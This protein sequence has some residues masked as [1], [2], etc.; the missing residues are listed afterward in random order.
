MNPND[1][2]D[3]VH[4]TLIKTVFKILAYIIIIVSIITALLLTYWNLQNPT[5]LDV[6]N[7]PFPVRP[8][9]NSPGDIEFIHVNYCKTFQAKGTVILNMVGEKSIIRLPFSIEN[10]PKQCLNTEVPIVIPVYAVNDTY[11]FDFKITYRINP[12]RTKVVELKSQTFKLTA[13]NIMVN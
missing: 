9:S 13:Q 11:Y 2:D 6:K 3:F 12:I 10:S 7:S 4:P 8:A 5:V 1:P